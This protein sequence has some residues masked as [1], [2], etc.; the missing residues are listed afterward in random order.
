MGSC[1]PSVGPVRPDNI[2]DPTIPEPVGAPI[3]K[4]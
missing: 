4:W 3:A 2:D 1:I